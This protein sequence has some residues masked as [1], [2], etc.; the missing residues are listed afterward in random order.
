MPC[1]FDICIAKMIGE[2]GKSNVR[3][4]Q[5]RTFLIYTT[6]KGEKL[7]TACSPQ[8]YYRACLFSLFCC[9][10]LP[11]CIDV[12]YDTKRYGRFFHIAVTTSAAV[13]LM[14]YN[15]RKIFDDRLNH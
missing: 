1:E 3:L 12:S 9:I 13:Q 10:L 4:I 8:E 6:V 7:L 5:G 11:I 14:S 15:M 2:E